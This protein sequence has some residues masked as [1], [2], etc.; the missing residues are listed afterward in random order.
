MGPKAK[1]AS[2]LLRRIG[3][4]LKTLGLYPP[5][6]PVADSAIDDLLHGLRAYLDTHGPLVVGV[7]KRSL[8]VDDATFTDLASASLA[9]HLYTRKAVGVT[10]LH[11]VSAHDLTMFLTVLRRDR[12][13]L[14]GEGG[15]AF[16]LQEAGI[17]SISVR[18]VL[19]AMAQPASPEEADAVHEIATGGVLSPQ[20]RH[21][22]MEILRAGQPA[23][24]GL[25]QGLHSALTES[26]AV[27]G[28]A[29]FADS[30]HRLVRSLDTIIGGEPVED[31]EKLHANLAATVLL[32]GEPIR[33]PMEQALVSSVGDNET[34]RQV[35]FRLA[36]QRLVALI[37]LSA[38]Q[39][40]VAAKGI[41]SLRTT[42]GHPDLP[43]QGETEAPPLPG[44]DGAEVCAG[45]DLDDDGGNRSGSTACDEEVRALDDED[46]M[47][48]D[49]IG[50]LV[51]AFRTQGGEPGQTGISGALAEALSWLV[52]RR[53]YGLLRAALQGLE[54]TAESTGV[55]DRAVWGGLSD[56]LHEGAV[57]AMLERL[58]GPR[59]GQ[60]ADDVKACLAFLAPQAV[61]FLMQVLAEEPVAATRRKLCDLI[62]DIGHDEVEAIGSCLT[63]G[64]WHLVRNAASILGR[65][66][67]PR[68]IAN[69][70]S[71]HGHPEYRVRREA[72]ESLVRIG[73]DEADAAIVAFVR[74]RDARIRH[75]AVVCLGDAGVYQAL[76]SLLAML[77]PADPFGRQA[78]IKAAIINAVARVAPVEAIPVLERVARQ[79]RLAPWSRR[80]CR[81]AR[82]A[83]ASIAARRTAQ[84]QTAPP[85]LRAQ[86]RSA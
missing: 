18:E 85:A 7:S 31:R 14:E 80:L 48:R 76:P 49:V 84:E 19:L 74:D 54:E 29:A 1:A 5:P 9:Y 75:K 10:I 16:L 37:P 72:I 34:A 59:P 57:R 43:V 65:L 24:T 66:E 33:G 26:G 4:A 51:D 12:D 77:E 32:L 73:T 70:A 27:D 21:E 47:T 3:V 42:E 71:L 82:D 50:T 25:F 63:D 40:D 62:V 30:A 79:R 52:S 15:L 61:P 81:Q 22:I 23:I 39:A 67:D 56:L 86:A 35:L 45:P 17:T 83:L 2:P 20:Q 68:S 78:P 44:I 36:S 41:A 8:R 55:H 60:D 53:E 64:R 58:W 38:L 69:L 11:G 6:S 28:Q 46:A 13:V